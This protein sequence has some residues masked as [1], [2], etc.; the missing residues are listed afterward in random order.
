MWPLLQPGPG[1]IVDIGDTRFSY[2]VWSGQQLESCLALDTETA[3]IESPATIPEL[4][5]ATASDGRTNVLI[6]PDDLPQ[7]IQ[8]HASHDISCHNI[9]FDFWVIHQHLSDHKDAQEMWWRMADHGRLHDTMLLDGLYR[10]ARFD[11]F[12]RPRDLAML[13]HEYADLEID[14]SDPFRTRYGSIIGK[15]WSSVPRGFFDYAVK[16][17]IVTFQVYT[18]LLRRIRQLLDKHHVRKE[19]IDTWGPLTEQHPDSGCNCPGGG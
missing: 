5:L 10:L 4:A 7:F 8:Q 18:Q 16:D 12:P 2:E 17:A 11:A 13:G 9:A 15:S 19:L 6:H 1:Q 3:K 14:K